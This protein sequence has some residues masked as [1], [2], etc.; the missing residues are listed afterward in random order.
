M[1][2]LYIISSIVLSFTSYS[3]WTV[4][5]A[6][7]LL[8]MFLVLFL[9]ELGHVIGGKTAGYEFLFMT[10]GPI[11]I[12]KSPKI[13]IVPNHSWMAFGGLASCVPHKVE[14]TDLV[15]KHKLFVAGGPAFTVL[16]TLIGVI[17]W[18][19]TDSELAFLFT[20]LNASIFIV[21]ATPFQGTYKSDGG[22]FLLL[23]KGG[24][25][26]ERFLAELLLIKEMMSSKYPAEWDKHLINEARFTNASTERIGTAILLFYYEIVRSN[27]QNASSC[28]H[29][30]KDLPL[31]KKSKINLQFITHI[32]QIDELLSE[33]PN[34]AFIKQ[35]H[36]NLSKTEPI[37]YTR[38]EAIIAY[39]QN[40]QNKAHELLDKVLDKCNKG[41]KQFGFY[42][43]INPVYQGLSFAK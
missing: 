15:K 18:I 21:T 8:T 23:Q 16:A 2:I 35:L 24:K 27:Y 19:I 36:V 28:I 31:T 29:S 26:A 12:E 11:T 13:R 1:F 4:I 30:F 38:S 10:V 7:G 20:I 33:K 41:V 39:L 37:S 40:D 6:L 42:E 34:F 22:V 3:E 14:L 43:S 5:I 25:E 32:R 9:H 17:L